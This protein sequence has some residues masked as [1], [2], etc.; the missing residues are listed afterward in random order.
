MENNNLLMIILAF[1]VGYCLQGMMKN[2]CGG[3]LVEGSFL[4]WGACGI[5]ENKN[6]GCDFDADC[7]GDRQ[8]GFNMSIG[9]CYGED[10]C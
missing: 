5:T 3:R 6:N 1:V 2:T 8:C 7:K 9:T 4:G 10:N